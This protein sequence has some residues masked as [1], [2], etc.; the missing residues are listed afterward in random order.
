MSPSDIVARMSECQATANRTLNEHHVA[1][2]AFQVA[3]ARGNWADAEKEED[4]ALELLRENL[5]AVQ[6]I[7]RLRQ[8]MS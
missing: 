2:Q 8:E 7:Y 1:V 4:L 3:C 5:D 6:A